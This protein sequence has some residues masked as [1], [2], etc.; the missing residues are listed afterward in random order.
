[1]SVALQVTL[2]LPYANVYPTVRA[3]S[4][5]PQLSEATPLASVADTEKVP[6]CDVDVPLVG[7]ID[8]MLGHESMG[9]VESIVMVNTGHCVAELTPVFAS[10]V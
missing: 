4:N 7:E 10:F 9:A 8:T 1:L 2:V 5:M 6:N 3:G